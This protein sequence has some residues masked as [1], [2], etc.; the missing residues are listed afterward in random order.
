MIV[1]R[2]QCQAHNDQLT[3]RPSTL[4]LTMASNISKPAHHQLTR[5][6]SNEAPATS[7]LAPIGIERANIQPP[8]VYE[9]PVQ[10]QTLSLSARAVGCTF[11]AS[12]A[13]SSSLRYTPT[14]T[15]HHCVPTGAG[16]QY[17]EFA[18]H[19]YSVRGSC[20][21][22]GGD[23]RVLLSDVSNAGKGRRWR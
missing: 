7:A 12:L 15:T 1:F 13:M 19:A 22:L 6:P 21:T 5:I 11:C 14:R 16:W 9:R 20:V 4:A 18:S 23:S 8:R 17:I 2:S 10:I 3:A